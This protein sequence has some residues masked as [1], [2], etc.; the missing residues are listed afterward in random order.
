MVKKRTKKYKHPKQKRILMQYFGNQVYSR[1]IFYCL[2]T[3][4]VLFLLM[5]SGCNKLVRIQEEKQVDRAVVNRQVK[6]VQSMEEMIIPKTFNWNTA[7]RIQMGLSLRSRSGEQ[8]S[9]VQ[10]RVYYKDN[11]RKDLHEMVNGISNREGK[12]GTTFNIPTYVK[13]VYVKTNQTGDTVFEIPIDSYEF[14]YTLRL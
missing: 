12:V 8:L 9:G 7:Q 6:S 1:F 10:I 14:D 4:C 5:G 3:F 11:V 2:V 13:S